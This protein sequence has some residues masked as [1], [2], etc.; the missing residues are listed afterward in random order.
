MAGLDL[1]QSKVSRHMSFLKNAGWVESDRK[2]KWVYYSLAKPNNPIQREILRVLRNTLP[3][4]TEAKQDYAR[5]LEYL[6]TKTTEACGSAD[7][8]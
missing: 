6:E 1:P 3:E 4:L 5:L 2:G 8:Q 7:Q